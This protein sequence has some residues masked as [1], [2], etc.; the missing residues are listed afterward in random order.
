VVGVWDDHDM[1]ANDCGME[2]EH[3][4]RNRLEFMKFI[5]EPEWTDRYL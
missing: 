4:E 1:G 5:G 3:K 2:F